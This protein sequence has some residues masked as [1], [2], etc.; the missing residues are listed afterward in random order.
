[1]V[2]DLLWREKIFNASSVKDIGYVI[3]PYC[4]IEM[5]DGDNIYFQIP[6][7]KLF[8]NNIILLSAKNTKIILMN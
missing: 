8:I 4:F 5:E 2:K 1:M 3:Y 7:N 6:L